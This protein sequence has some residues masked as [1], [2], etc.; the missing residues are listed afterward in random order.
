MNPSV[1]AKKGLVSLHEAHGLV[2]VNIF[3]AYRC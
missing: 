2:F 3:L 1:M